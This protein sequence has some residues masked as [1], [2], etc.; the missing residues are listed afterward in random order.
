MA[1]STPRQESDDFGGSLAGDASIGGFPCSDPGRK[2]W[3]PASAADCSP[4]R[5]PRKE[6]NH[7][8]SGRPGK[9]GNRDLINQ[10][11]NLSKY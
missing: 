6:R 1:G 11:E 8:C 3:E 5:S 2:I 7:C 4:S 10:K 9:I